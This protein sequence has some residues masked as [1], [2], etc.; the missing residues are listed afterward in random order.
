MQIQTKGGFRR[1]S[2][3]RMILPR[4]RVL[5]GS[6]R[7]LLQRGTKVGVRGGIAVQERRVGGP[8][9]LGRLRRR[10]TVLGRR[11]DDSMASTST[12][13]RRKGRLNFIEPAPLNRGY[14]SPRRPPPRLRL[15]SGR[16]EPAARP[17]PRETPHSGRIR[18]PAPRPERQK[19]RPLTQA[20]RVEPAARRLLFGS[21]PASR[22][23]NLKGMGDEAT[24]ADGAA[25]ASRRP[26]VGEVID[27]KQWQFN[28]EQIIGNGALASWATIV[29]NGRRYQKSRNNE[30][31]SSGRNRR[32]CSRTSASRIGN[33]T[34]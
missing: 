3:P 16:E 19:I 32:K 13:Q 31:T 2:G 21:G 10:L 24:G 34:S 26:N 7:G 18:P 25:G 14:R 20:S 15:L 23:S 12:Q 29:E 1:S 30:P 28:A 5:F 4:G 17:R 27:G 9:R 11:L 8:S 6:R 22:G 33:C